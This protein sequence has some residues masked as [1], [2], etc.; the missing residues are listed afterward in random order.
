MKKSYF[1]ALFILLQ[2]VAKG[3]VINQFS[4]FDFSISG[5]ISKSFTDERNSDVAV[6]GLA[7]ITYN[8]TPYINYVAEIQGGQFM[9]NSNYANSLQRDFKTN[10]LAPSF[11]VQFQ[12]GEFVDYN[13]SSFL[14]TLKNMYISPGI[15]VI[16]TRSNVNTIAASGSSYTTGYDKVVDY[17]MFIPARLGY[18]FKIFVE[19]EPFMKIDVGYQFNYLIGDKLDGNL[20]GKSNDMFHQLTLGF[21]FAIPGV[22]TYRKPI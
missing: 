10:Y 20:S 12:L 1:V 16:Y 2:L 22:T 8:Q 6:L 13:S 19:D 3:Q 7:G 21:K 11:R 15:G 18:E 4:R 9:G 14:N 5:G 17:S